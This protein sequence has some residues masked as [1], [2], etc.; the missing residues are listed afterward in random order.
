MADIF[1]ALNNLH[2]QMQ[3]GEVNILK[4]EEHLKAFKKKNTM[5]TMSRE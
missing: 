5:K 3:G 4:V 2:L 1:D